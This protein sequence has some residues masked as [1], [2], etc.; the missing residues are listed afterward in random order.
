MNKVMVVFLLL[1][2]AGSLEGV[3][4]KDI[5]LR[6]TGTGGEGAAEEEKL[7]SCLRCNKWGWSQLL[8][9]SED[10]VIDCLTLFS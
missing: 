8:H 9:S 10:L 2:I 3:G 4:K 5:A 6:Y 7:G 1:C